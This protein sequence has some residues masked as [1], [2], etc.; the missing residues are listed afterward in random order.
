MPYQVN[1]T[2]KEICIIVDTLFISLATLGN[3][4]KQQTANKMK[5]ITMS[6]SFNRDASMIV[7]KIAPLRDKEPKKEFDSLLT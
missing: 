7:V 1:N 4:E 5:F 3:S 6:L 2:V